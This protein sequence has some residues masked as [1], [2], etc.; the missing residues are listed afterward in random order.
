MSPAAS[1]PFA[2]PPQF[3]ERIAAV[4][5]AADHILG[6]DPEAAL[7]VSREEYELYLAAES[8][9]GRRLH[10]GHALHNIG[11]A[12]HAR[13]P[14]EGRTYFHAA[15][16]EDARSFP[17][18]SQE[19]GW[20]AR[21]MLLNLYGERL[22]LIE[23]VETLARSSNDEPV[24]LARRFAAEKGTFEEFH[25]I[26]EGWRS[27]SELDQFSSD[28]LVFCGGSRALPMGFK[29]LAAGAEAANLQPVVVMEFEDQ[30]GELPYRKSLRLLD[31]CRLA[32]FDISDPQGQIEEMTVAERSG[33]P[34]FAAFISNDPLDKQHGSS[35]HVG[36]VDAAGTRARACRGYD[37]MEAEVRDWCRA[38]PPV[39]RTPFIAS[40]KQRPSFLEGSNFRSRGSA[41]PDQVVVPS[42]SDAAAF[43]S[44]AFE[45]LT[46]L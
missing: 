24:R 33:T 3:A 15:H 41:F 12:I 35:M 27:E 2:L 10:K 25:G 17:G 37:E 16:I 40:L 31:R 5:R 19:H 13:D 4:G 42:G 9:S 14:E 39:L 45:G 1:D 43:L 28:Q 21:Q 46:L 22:S 18:G 23:Q 36:L 44:E 11:V 8:A 6:K 32:A 20:I 34:I 26:T 29:A 38:Q 30:P 7:T